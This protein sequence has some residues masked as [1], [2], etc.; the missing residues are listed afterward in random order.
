MDIILHDTDSNFYWQISQNNAD[1]I[2]WKWAVF[3]S[4]VLVL[5]SAAEKMDLPNALLI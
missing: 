3:P 2:S 1:M 4:S 5:T